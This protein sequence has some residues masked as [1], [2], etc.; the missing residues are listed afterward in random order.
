MD[1]NLPVD[2]KDSISSVSDSEDNE[3]YELVQI[4]V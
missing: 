4:N 2:V 3:H 1:I